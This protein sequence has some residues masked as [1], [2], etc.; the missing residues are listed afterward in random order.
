MNLKV[1]KMRP[2]MIVPNYAKFRGIS[3]L[4]YFE[5]WHEKVS[6]N[7]DHGKPEN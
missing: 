1:A 2:V 3:L 7:Y 6:N 4:L 5:N